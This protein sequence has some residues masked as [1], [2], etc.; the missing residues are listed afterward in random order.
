MNIGMPDTTVVLSSK[1]QVSR[2]GG[3]LTEVPYHLSTA[4]L[5]AHIINIGCV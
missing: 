2:A 1:L 3:V 5:Y 4:C